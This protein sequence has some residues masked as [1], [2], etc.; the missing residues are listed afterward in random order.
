MKV[1][2][3]CLLL[4][5]L[6]VSI[7]A[8]AQTED[9]K[10]VYGTL[11]PFASEAVYFLMTDRFVDGDPSNNY[12]D[13]GGEN[14]T[15]MAEMV[16][17]DGN[18]KAY[19][20]YMGGDFKGILDHADYIKSMGFSAIWLTPI[21]NNPDQAFTGGEPITFGGAFKDGGKTGYHGYWGVN[22]FELDEHLPSEDLDFQ[23]LVSQLEQQHGIKTILD[24]V[25]NH[26]SPSFT[27]PE[28]Q[29][30]FGEL[31]DKDGKL[32][33]DH[34][35][36]DPSE[37]DQENP[38][39][40]MFN[41]K[42]DI[43]QLSD[44]NENEP[45]VMDYFIAAY[46]QW[47]GQG[48]HALRID[49]IK[50]MPTDFWSRFAK[51][52]REG[53][54]D[55]FMFAEAFSY[56]AEF[57]GQYTQTENGK[58]SVLDFPLRLA[59]AEVFQDPNGDLKKIEQNLYLNNG[60]YENPYELM[61]FYDNH[62]M[63]RINTDTR[64]YINVHNLLFTLR[65]I[66]V[67]YYGSESGFMSGTAEHAGNRNYFGV[68][69]IAN[70]KQSPIF[71]GLTAI[72]KVR[73]ENIALQRGLQINLSFDQHQA[74]FMRIYEHE[75][76][77]QTA[78]V[79]FNKDDLSAVIEVEDVLSNGNWTEALSGESMTINN[80]KQHTFKLPANS[81]QVWLFNGENNNKNLVD[82]L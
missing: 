30:M 55:L 23:Q 58:I 38:L 13:Q 28:D 76:I 36:T 6:T 46:Q 59:L 72:A 66:P 3:H 50:H 49:T 79:L 14:P 10:S 62:D 17:E 81:I 51:R 27:M 16:S 8:L 40:K 11:E 18:N 5:V 73:Q 61:T 68:E 21:V 69:G 22:F 71:A 35:N 34:M 52:I 77:H 1:L 45:A 19:V 7:S 70:A 65:G 33:A 75:G 12:L 53:R 47:L 4:I 44:L 56:D 80:G 37:L 29:P 15:W 39:H 43:L 82:R 26:G 20:G 78:L 41:N 63:A 54:E 64:G 67:I 24:V 9:N 42:P 48:A 57:I 60:P 25:L 74:S 31:Y 2:Q 32:V